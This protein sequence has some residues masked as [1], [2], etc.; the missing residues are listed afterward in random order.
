MSAAGS[1]DLFIPTTP[2]K[3]SHDLLVFEEG[4]GQSSQNTEVKEEGQ[5]SWAFVKDKPLETCFDVLCDSQTFQ[6][7]FPYSVFTEHW[8]FVSDTASASVERISW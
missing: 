8:I 6:V 5:R 1:G 4:Q 7:D 3:E 2:A